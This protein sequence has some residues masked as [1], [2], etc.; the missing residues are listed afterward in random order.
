RP[1][2]IPGAF[3]FGLIDS[4]PNGGRRTSCCA[5]PSGEPPPRGTS[6]MAGSAGTGSGENPS[7]FSGAGAGGGGAGAEP[8]VWGVGSGGSLCNSVGGRL[9]EVRGPVFLGALGGAVGAPTT[10][11]LV[12]VQPEERSS[13]L[14]VGV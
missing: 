2:T 14:L 1:R 11:E 13:T 9:G 7:G 12:V 6:G 3:A 8:C 10:T 4:S 5:P